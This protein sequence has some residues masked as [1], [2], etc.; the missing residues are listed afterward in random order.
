MFPN[1]LIVSIQYDTLGSNAT[2]FPVLTFIISPG[3][4][5]F[6]IIS[7]STSK[8]IFPFPVAF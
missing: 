5:S 7:P 3:A 6:W 2:T 8:K 4:K 1:P